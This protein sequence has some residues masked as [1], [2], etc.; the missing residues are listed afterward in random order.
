MTVE[1][2]E[3][4][5][6]APV[7][8]VV[9]EAQIGEEPTLA[10]STYASLREA[11]PDVQHPSATIPTQGG[12][13]L[14]VMIGP[15][16]VLFM[17]EN[18]MR[19]VSMSATSI[20]VESTSYGRYELFRDYLELALRRIEAAAPERPLVKRI[21]LRYVDE[22]R[23]PG[24]I[25]TADDWAPYVSA[26][27]LAPSR[28]GLEAGPAKSFQGIVEHRADEE[29]GFNVRF[30]AQHG[31][32]VDPD[33]PLSLPEPHLAGPY[34]LLDLDSYWLP[35]TPSRLGADVI[36]EV[37]DRLRAPIRSTFEANITDRLR[38]ELRGE[39]G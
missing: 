8:Y 7:R 17:S 36:L 14:P 1:Q 11:F 38:A 31:F 33:G 26:E 29:Y 30:G 19:A 28:I 37:A 23:V 10:Y 32:T 5:G 27:L 13:P 18:R 4:Y 22:I 16:R 3:I 21:G 15:T 34:F 6:N 9:L 20:V 12:M 2:R 24:A 25:N 35:K 39:E